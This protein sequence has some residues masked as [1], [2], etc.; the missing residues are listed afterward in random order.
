MASRASTDAPITGSTF[1]RG[2]SPSLDRNALESSAV[3]EQRS[4]AEL[5][6]SPAAHGAIDLHE[7]VRPEIL[8]PGRI[9]GNHLR[10]ALPAVR[11]GLNYRGRSQPALAGKSRE[12]F[13]GQTS[14]P[15]GPSAVD[16]I[17]DVIQDLI[18]SQ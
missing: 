7:T 18:A 4:S 10:R 17:D 8:N 14:D 3:C 1:R 11:T 15:R 9:E 6:R 12:Q 2:L 13:V 16:Q 5:H